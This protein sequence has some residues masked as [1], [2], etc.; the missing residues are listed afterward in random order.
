MDMSCDFVIVG[1]GSA[2]CVLANRLSAGGRHRVVL[3]EAGRD[4]PPDRV[5]P[6]ILDSYPRVAYFDPRNLW[7]ELR[8]HLRPV[9]AG[10]GDR[11]PP[12]RYEQ[13][14]I[15]GGGSSLND[16]QANRGL[17]DDYEEWAASGAEGWGWD[18]VLPYFRRLERDVDFDGPLHGR[19]GPVAIRRIMPS[20]WPGFSRAAAAA[21]AEAGH[22]ALDDQNG[23][24]RDGYFP[25]AISNL[26]DRRVSAAIAYLDNAA[27]RRT[28][29]TILPDTVATRLVLDGTTV[30]GV[31][32]LGKGGPLR[33]HARETILAAGAIHTPAMLLRAGIG[34]AEDLRAAGVAVAADRRGVGRNLQEHPAISVSAWMEPGAR[35][36]ASLRRHIHL[37]LRYS[38]GLEGCPRGDMYMVAL[39]KTGW[40]PVGRQLG[41]LVTWVNKSYSRGRVRLASADPAAE[42][43][44]EF[45]M[46]SDPRDAAR[47]KRGLRE[48]A[49]LFDAAPLREV[50]RHPFPTS[51]SERVRQLGIVSRRNLVLTSILAACLD[52]PDW[53]RRTLLRRVVTEGAPLAAVLADEDVMDGFV[54]TAVHGLWHASGSCRMGRESDPDAVVTPRGRVIGVAGLRVVDASVM[55][56]IPRANTNVPTLM[57]AE[58]MSAHILA[59]AEARAAEVGMLQA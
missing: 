38:S 58:K 37:G 1:G 28:N 16:M 12:V 11:A 35:L 52:G 13:A 8:V 47:L 56:S 19:E 18:E 17:P 6:A 43:R 53:L 32:A 3:I 36:Q 21:M 42:P 45:A 27:R 15:M 5:E 2:G 23:D 20:V 57:L 31:E 49:R 39:S 54:R 33:V 22:E 14:R 40:H 51:Y 25:V 4:Q 29:L 24:F 34:P 50:A 41:S 10:T 48:A 59:D 55:P 30:R 44:V 26:Y 7:A 9:A 46:L